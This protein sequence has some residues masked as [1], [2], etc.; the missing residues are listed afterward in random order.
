MRL[1]RDD[2][3]R[4]GER[5]MR[6]RRSTRRGAAAPIDDGTLRMSI[7]H[8]GLGRVVPQRR[9]IE[10]RKLLGV[11]APTDTRRQGLGN[12]CPDLGSHGILRQDLELR[13]QR[14]RESRRDLGG[15]LHH[16]PGGSLL[17][18]LRPQG[19][20]RHGQERGGVVERRRVPRRN[21]HLSPRLHLEK[22]LELIRIDMSLCHRR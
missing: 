1:R 14:R 10:R 13:Q 17:R 18:D 19:M 4:D 11:A 8:R 12:R 20:R 6:T 21:R 5:Q 7:L 2:Q 9:G 3:N 22:H 15:N 16:G